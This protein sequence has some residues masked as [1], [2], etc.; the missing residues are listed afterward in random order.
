MEFREWLL[1]E[2]QLKD[3]I[4]QVHRLKDSTKAH[5]EKMVDNSSM[6]L[7][8]VGLY[9]LITNKIWIKTIWVKAFRYKRGVCNL[10]F[11]LNPNEVEM[12]D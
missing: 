11:R 6:A 2:D 1:W 7:L 5:K 4:Y 8:K 10:D 9:L 12:L 3:L